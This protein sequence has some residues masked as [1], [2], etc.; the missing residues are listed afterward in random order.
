M[1]ELNARIGRTMQ[2]PFM[3]VLVPSGGT[4]HPDPVPRHTDPP[5]GRWTPR[6][7]GRDPGESRGKGRAASAQRAGMWGSLQQFVRSVPAV[8]LLLAALLLALW[9]HWRWMSRRLTDGSDEPWGMLALATVAVLVFRDRARLVPPSRNMLIASAA[10]AVAAAALEPFVPSLAA[11]A[12][13]L[14]ALGAFLV[15]A[16]P[17][18]PA[19][20]LLTLLALALPIIASLQFYFGYPLR[21][22]TAHAAAAL[23]ALTG[24]DVVAR[25][26]A[27]EFAGRT[28]LVDPPCAG[29][30]MLWVGSYTA[31]LMSYLDG[32]ST[33][34]TLAN[35][36]VAAGGVFAANVLRNALLF[37]PESGLVRAPA[38]THDAIGLAAFALAIVPVVAFVH[39]RRA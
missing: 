18:R 11:A 13:A 26:A 24:F 15:G 25:G 21:L 12:I 27:F 35:G 9:P 23:L 38:W 34:R 3:G 1:S 36:V 17:Q 4:P 28:I 31:A 5:E 32:A 37:F 7:G 22:A 39:G 19:A 10:L 30:G 33:R 16:A 6:G 29:I 14:L 20:P 2:G 8:W